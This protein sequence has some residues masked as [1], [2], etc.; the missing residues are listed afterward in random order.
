MFFKKLVLQGEEISL[1]LDK[2]AK[3]DKI[4]DWLPSHYF[5]IRDSRGTVV[6]KCDLRIGH[7][8]NSYYAGNIGYHVFIE[9]RGHH[10]ALKA[11]RLLFEYA[12]SLGMKYLIITCDPDNIASRKTCEHLGGEFLEMAELPA[13]NLLRKSGS[14]HKCIFRYELV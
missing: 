14:T 1:E 2:K 5:F 3:E 6:G 10:Y 9:Y 11:C 7:N 8:E 12:K 4:A 13:E